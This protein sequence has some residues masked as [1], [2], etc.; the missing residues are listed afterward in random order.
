MFT[1]EREIKSMRISEHRLRRLIRQVISEVSD[2][3]R[4][5]DKELFFKKIAEGVS[6]V[7]FVNDDQFYSFEY[8]RSRFG[9]KI[10]NE[11]VDFT[12][13]ESGRNL[14]EELWEEHTD[15]VSYMPIDVCVKRVVAYLED[16]GLRTQS[17]KDLHRDIK[18]RERKD[19]EARLVGKGLKN[20]WGDK[21]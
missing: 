17:S 12:M 13:T 20:I 19:L 18:N 9:M 5:V 21:I 1:L 6:A 7:F 16:L 11:E 2:S 15:S 3:S 8:N 4:T 10:N 14:L